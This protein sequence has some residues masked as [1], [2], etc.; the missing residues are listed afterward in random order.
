MKLYG[1]NVCPFVHRVRLVL[2]EKNLEHEYVNIDLYNKPDWYHDVLPTGKVPLLEHDG[3]RLWESS[4]VCEY[5]EE[6]FPEHPLMP[7]KPGPRAEARILLESASSSFVPLFYKLLRAQQAEQQQQFERELGEALAKL[8]SQAFQTCDEWLYG[9]SLSLVDLEVYPWI[10]RWCVLEH[11][12]GVKF[13]PGLSKLSAW[14][15]RM[16]ARV[17]VAQLKQPDQFFIDQYVHYAVA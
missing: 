13:P 1:A 9:S 17:T 15:E 2:A 4:I 12:R 10:E 11:Y 3:H 8:E 7:A 16:A 14:K 6:A 5:L